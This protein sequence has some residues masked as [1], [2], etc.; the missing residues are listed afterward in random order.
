M[1]L[2]GPYLHLVQHPRPHPCCFTGDE[3]STGTTESLSSSPYN[4]TSLARDQA[5][6]TIWEAFQ[7]HLL[8]KTQV[9]NS[10]LAARRRDHL[11]KANFEAHS[12]FFLEIIGF[13]LRGTPAA[14]QIVII[15]Y[16]AVNDHLVIFLS[17]PQKKFTNYYSTLC[18]Y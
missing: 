5:S 18:L 8:I 6:C 3:S 11:F 14:I 4:I 13:Q 10:K 7:F 17:K 1:A 12:D 2:G 15:L 16:A 9:A